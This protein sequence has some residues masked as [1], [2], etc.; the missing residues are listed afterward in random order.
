MPRSKRAEGLT[1]REL[2]AVAA[3]SGA[4][5][6]IGR[7][8]AALAG[9]PTMMT[10]PI[11]STGEPLPVVGLGTWQTFDVGRDA[12]ERAPL[13]AVLAGLLEAG[14]RLIDSSPMYGRSE[15]V[16]GDLL[17]ERPAGPRP[18]VATKVWTRGRAEGERAMAESERRMGGRLD[19]LQVHNLLDVQV[20]LPTLRDWKARGRIRYLGIT[21][22]ARSAFPDLE[23]LL[24]TE[25]LDFVQLPYS[26]A[27]RE[28]EERLLPLARERGVAVMVMRPFEEG[29][30]FRAVKGRP[31]PPWAAEAGCASW[32]ALFLKFILAHPAVTV[33]IPATANPAH[34]AQNV[35]AGRGPPLDRAQRAR[36]VEELSR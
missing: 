7:P 15:A 2:L 25:P 16:V 35:E 10:R 32:A 6:A 21:H 5:Y 36:L 1:R 31:V 12:A 14:G 19:L 27:S 33:A 22:Y 8:L 26:A 30:L 28:A 3:A 17:A 20:H 13:R 23:R 24:R 18:F 11:P 4:A 9:G 29:A 34:L